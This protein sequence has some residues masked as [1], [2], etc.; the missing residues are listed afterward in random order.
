MYKL[1]VMNDMDTFQSIYNQK[2]NSTSSIKFDIYINEN[3]SFFT[4]DQYIMSLV[5]NIRS[6][7]Y[8]INEILSN[9]P[10]IAISQYMRKSLIDEIEYTNKIEGII[11]TRKDINDLISEIEKKASTQNRLQ[12]IVHKYL[13]LTE[14]KLTFNDASDIRKLYDEMLFDEIKL[15]DEQNLPDGKMFRKEEVH[16]YKSGEKIV[17]NGIMPE[18]KIID[19][20][21]KALKILNDQSI[22][23]LVRVALFHYYFG[24]IHPFYDGN[25]RINRFISSYI[26]SKYFNKVIGFR[27]SMTIKENLTQ[28]L[29]AFA[30]TND[31]RNKGDVSTFIYEFLDIICKSYQKTEIYALEKNKIFDKYT[32]I[33]DKVSSLFEMNKNKNDINQL[34]YILVQCS[35]FGDFGLSKTNLCRVLARGNTKI[36]EYLGELKNHHLCLTIQSGKHFYYKANLETLDKFENDDN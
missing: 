9:L 28:Y 25:G 36:T 27:L 34:L 16:I 20:M 4:Y 6:L 3:Q 17:H 8:Q 13:L 32:K 14:E 2:F 22:D 18:S 21:N 15:E 35:V 23:I 1:F 7:D 30:H 29:D 5:S 19:Y 33:L 24:Y 12:G 10:L 26:L 31:V 11:V